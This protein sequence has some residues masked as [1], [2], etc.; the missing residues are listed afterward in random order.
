MES[1]ARCALRFVRPPRF[2]GPLSFASRWRRW[3]GLRTGWMALF[4]QIF[5]H[6]PQPRQKSVRL[7]T[8][9]MMGR[10]ICVCFG[11]GTLASETVSDCFCIT[12]LMALNEQLA[13]QLP[14]IVQRS[15]WYSI[16]QG[17][18]FTPTS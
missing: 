14:H 13:T 15:A 3:S 1:S 2:S 4:G 10:A 8:C 7:A 9:L 11:V 6:M 17:R 5:S 18:S 12:T 16:I